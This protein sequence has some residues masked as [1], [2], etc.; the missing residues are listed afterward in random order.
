MTLHVTIVLNF[1]KDTKFVEKTANFLE[2]IFEKNEKNVS[3]MGKDCAV[4]LYLLYN[5]GVSCK[6]FDI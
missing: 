1:G 2:I 3:N 4:N 6:F 5:I